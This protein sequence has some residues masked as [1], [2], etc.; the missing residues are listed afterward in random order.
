MPSCKTALDCKAYD[1]PT[2]KCGHATAID[3]FSVSTCSHWDVDHITP[4][5]GTGCTP[6]DHAA[7]NLGYNGRETIC[8]EHGECTKGCYVDKDCPQGTSCSAQGTLGTCK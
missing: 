4:P 1:A 6:L 2:S 5:Y 3:S 7:C 8:S